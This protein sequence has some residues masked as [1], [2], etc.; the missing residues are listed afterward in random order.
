MTTIEFKTELILTLYSKQD[1]INR[2]PR[3][4]PPKSPIE[5]RIWV[6][7]SG[8]GLTRSKDFDLAEYPV[9][10]L[11]VKSISQIIN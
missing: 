11:S 7:S 6:D 1:W 5:Q 9:F 3:D 10:V 2:V 8:D 4:L